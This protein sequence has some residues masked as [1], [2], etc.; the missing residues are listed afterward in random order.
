MKGGNECIDRYM[1]F[2]KEETRGENER[3]FDTRF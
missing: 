1:A 2:K 3:H